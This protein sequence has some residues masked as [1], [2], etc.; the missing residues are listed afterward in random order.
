MPVA[1]ETP[2]MVAKPATIPSSIVPTSPLAQVVR[3]NDDQFFNVVRWTV[4]ALIAA[5]ELGVDIAR[6]RILR[7]DTQTGI[8]SGPKGRLG[9]TERNQP[10]TWA[11]AGTKRKAS[12]V[13]QPL[14]RS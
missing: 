6:I 7:P 10:A 13:P 2:A 8:E 1:P 5:E 4:F 3:Q 9:S 11:S 14:A 12:T